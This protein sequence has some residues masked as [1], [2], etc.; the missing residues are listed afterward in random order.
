MAPRLRRMKSYHP[1]RKR[2]K[3]IDVRKQAL[4]DLHHKISSDVGNLIVLIKEGNKAQIPEAQ[5]KAKIDYLKHADEMQKIAKD[6]GNHFVRIVREYLDSVDGIV[7][8]DPTWLDEE[9]I[10]YCHKMAEKLE[11]EIAA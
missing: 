3:G 9:K 7:H 8:T 2:A 11:K 1:R 5:Q 6:L 10:R 4:K